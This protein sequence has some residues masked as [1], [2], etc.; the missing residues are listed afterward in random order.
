MQKLAQL[1]VV[2][3]LVFPLLAQT[4]AA[5]EVRPATPEVLA[6][7]TP[8]TTVE[9][10][11]F[12]APAGWSIAVRDRATILEA[13]EGGS[14]IALVDVKADDADAAVAAAWKQYG[15]EP[16]WP[17]INKAEGADRDGWTSEIGRA[18][19]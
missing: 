18:S 12:L 9:G 11:K 13:P 17:L 1:A 2:A 10:N 14:R 3:L 16:K 5:P 7:D 15:V 19:W 6:A 4:S 8:R